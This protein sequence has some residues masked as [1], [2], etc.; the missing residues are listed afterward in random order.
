MRMT[1]AAGFVCSDGIL[2]CADTEHT[3][4]TSKSHHSKVDHFEVPGGKVCFALAGSS[5]LAWSAIQKCK[6]QLQ[7][8][9]SDD[10]ASD[11]EV[12][13]D[14]EYR[15]NVLTHPNYASLDYSLLVGL[16]TERGSQLYCTTAT[17]LREIKDFECI[18]IGGELA[19]FIVRQGLPSLSL[20]EAVAL[21]AYT[22]AGVKEG[23]TGCG[24]MSVYLLLRNDGSTG[25]L[26]SQHEGATKNLEKNARL[27]DFTVRRLLVWMADMQAED[28]H[29]E[30]NVSELVMK[31]LIE[32][33]N[34]WRQTYKLKQRQFAELNPHL[35]P[36]QVE[37][38]FGDISF[39]F[40]PKSS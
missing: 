22:L 39:G 17:A 35:T 13:L 12:I 24:G 15:R 14:A 26:T 2:L 3:G 40:S 27:F 38:M 9:Q 7:A 8:E 4:W 36:S 6:K 33:R 34:E 11:I 19:Q 18:G 32:K 5:A 28:I 20:R 16:W 25:V 30:Q 31:P 23:I 37:E 1:I 10:L 29:L 21:A